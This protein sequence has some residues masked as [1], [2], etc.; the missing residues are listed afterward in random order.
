MR[1]GYIDTPQTLTG[2][3]FADLSWHCRCQLCIWGGLK[4]P[5]DANYR[6]KF[7][8]LLKFQHFVQCGIEDLKI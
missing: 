8:Y 2:Q 1:S 3:G 5:T 6:G 4:M 7:D